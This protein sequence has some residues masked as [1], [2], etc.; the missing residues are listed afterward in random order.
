MKSK[1]H[2]GDLAFTKQ[3]PLEIDESPIRVDFLPLVS[4]QH[5]D[6]PF[7]DTQKIDLLKNVHDSEELEDLDA[8]V[9]CQSI[10]KGEFLEARAGL[11]WAQQRF[12]RGPSSKWDDKQF[13]FQT[14][15]G[16]LWCPCSNEK[17]LLVFKDKSFLK[18]DTFTGQFE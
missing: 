5:R 3:G 10:Y 11:A 16:K 12:P 8:G 17:D 15:I 2:A 7:E 13:R 9:W 18:L 14:E 1:I 6:N 4:P